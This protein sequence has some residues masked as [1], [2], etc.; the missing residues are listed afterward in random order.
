MSEP[1][2]SDVL[3]ER[4]RRRTLP[5]GEDG[6]G[7]VEATLVRRFP[8]AAHALLAPLADVDVLYVHGWSD[9]FFQAEVAHFWNRLGARFYALDLRKYGRSLRPGQT[10]GYVDSLDTYREDIDAALEAI[11]HGTDASPSRRLVVTGHSTGG[12]SLSLWAAANPGRAAALVLNSPWLELQASTVGRQVIAPLV[13]LHARLDPRA[14][15]PAVDF[16]FYTRAQ[17]EVGAIPTEA[18]Q[19]DWRP[20]RGFTARPGWFR[21]IL[22]GQTRIAAGIDVGCPALVLLSARSSNPFAWSEAMTRTDGVLVVD[23]IARASLKLGP[24]VGVERVPDAIHDVYLS[25]AEPRADAFAR[26]ARF[27]LGVLGTA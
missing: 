1:W 9:Y 6:E 5:L 2:R 12:L 7:P 15:Y 3:G 26:T 18:Y 19:R 14:Q 25:R 16:G 13:T 23:D 24:S 8:D 21:A 11:G 22:A 4:F 27:A 20:D 10:A 17:T